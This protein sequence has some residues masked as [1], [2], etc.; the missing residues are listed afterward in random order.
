MKLLHV[1]WC[2][3]DSSDKVYAIIELKIISAPYSKLPE[4]DSVQYVRIWG[5]RGKSLRHKI[6]TA[7]RYEIKNLFASKVKKNYIVID[8]TKLNEL[9]PEFEEDLKEIGIWA[10]LSC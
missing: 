4:Y 1:G 5:P 9:Y 3:K 10:R 2:N 7:Q 6:D 8:E